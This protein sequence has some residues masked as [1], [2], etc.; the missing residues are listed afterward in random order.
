LSNLETKPFALI[1]DNQCL[2]VFI[3]RYR[4]SSMW[5]LLLPLNVAG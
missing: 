1:A 3:C 2:K 5:H 4:Q